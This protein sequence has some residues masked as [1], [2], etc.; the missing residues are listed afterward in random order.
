MSSVADRA[1]KRG[2]AVDGLTLKNASNNVASSGAP[3]ASLRTYGLLFLQ[4]FRV[5]VAAA[6][7]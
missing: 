7:A 4:A 6:T 1:M 3:P 2:I 5:E